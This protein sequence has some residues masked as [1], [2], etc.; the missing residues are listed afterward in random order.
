M[1]LSATLPRP[2][3][4]ARK[5]IASDEQAG[6]DAFDLRGG[7]RRSA[8]LAIATIESMKPVTTWMICEILFT[9]TMMVS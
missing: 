2:T 9:N 8:P 4:P 3:K 7:R 1:I 5:L 6:Q